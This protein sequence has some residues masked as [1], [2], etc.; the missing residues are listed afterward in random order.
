MKTD[1]HDYVYPEHREDER[2]P[3]PYEREQDAREAYGDFLHD[4]MR[5]RQMEERR[6]HEKALAGIQPPP[7]DNCGQPA[8]F[9]G[10][11]PEAG[12]SYVCDGCWRGQGF[13][14]LK[15]WDYW[16]KPAAPEP[17]EEFKR[18][19]DAK[20]A[21][22]T[23]EQLRAELEAVGCDFTTPAERPTPITDAEADHARNLLLDYD[24]QGKDD[25]IPVP[26][27]VPVEVSR[28]LERQL[29][30][31]REQHKH[32]SGNLYDEQQAHGLTKGKLTEAKIE[33]DGL[34]AEAARLRG[35]LRLVSEQLAEANEVISMYRESKASLPRYISRRELA[36][37]LAAERTL[38]DRLAGDLKKIARN[39]GDCDDTGF[40][41]GHIARAAL[42]AWEEARKE[43]ADAQST[44]VSDK[45]P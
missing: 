35:E 19:L 28:N 27:V 45:T 17:V 6:E 15:P 18:E 3:T 26:M 38:A 31:A 10:S 29:A 22:T 39:P 14:N 1:D 44:P 11:H 40:T 30:E 33:R 8:R 9:V 41:S 42:T 13:E 25:N 21:A 36:Y 16:R 34:R 12:H 2:E 7:C 5:D 43:N 20:L 23:D 32:T 24:C 37:Q 4:E